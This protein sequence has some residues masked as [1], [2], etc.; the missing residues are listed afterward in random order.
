MIAVYQMLHSG[1]DMDH[2]TFFKVSAESTTRG[3][4]WK[5][6]KP[7]A[8]TRIRRNTFSVRVVNDWNA[9]P[10]HVVSASTVNIFKARLDSHWAHL[11]YT[12][13]YQD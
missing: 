1:V 9:L 2:T 10:L 11:Q 12:I 4:P 5:I 3:H 7:Q 13:P 8:L 6:N